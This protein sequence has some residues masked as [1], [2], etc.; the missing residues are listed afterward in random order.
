VEIVTDLLVTFL[1]LKWFDD[2]VVQCMQSVDVTDIKD[3]T[4]KRE[5]FTVLPQAIPQFPRVRAK[6]VS[7]GA[8]PDLL[9]YRNIKRN[10][11]NSQVLDHSCD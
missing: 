11:I 1:Q 6:G 5:F 8:Y 7:D 4:L 2:P 3:V 10:A 9:T